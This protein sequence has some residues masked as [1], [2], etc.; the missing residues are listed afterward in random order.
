MGYRPRY[1]F[2]FD[3]PEGK[4]IEIVIADDSFDGE[5]ETRPLG[6]SPVLR[7]DTSDNVNGMSLEIPAECD[8]EDEYADLYTTDPTRFMVTLYIND[9][10]AWHGFITPELYAAPWVDPPY[11]V[12]LTAT[13]GLGEL[14]RY[15]YE[16]RGRR[17][18]EDHLI[19]LLSKTGLDLPLRYVSKL[20]HENTTDGYFFIDTAVSMDNMAGET[21]YDVLQA[22]LTSIHA[23]IRQ[24]DGRWLV[25][26]ETDVL[27]SIDGTT[28]RDNMGG[29]LDIVPF[30]SMQSNDV[31]P[32]GRLTSEIVPARN[33]VKI[34]APNRPSD[35]LLPDGDMSAGGWNTNGR[36]EQAQRRYWLGPSR[37]MSCYAVL[38]PMIE[39]STAPDL[40]LTVS[41]S[42][43]DTDEAHDVKMRVGVYGKMLDSSSM[44][45][46]Y[47]AESQDNNAMYWDNTTVK[48]VS[49]EL[50][51]AAKARVPVR[52]PQEVSID[53]PFQYLKD[54]LLDTINSIEV[55]I[56]AADAGVIVYA[57]RLVSILPFEGV[58]TTVS[59]NNGARGAAS[60]VEV[61]FADTY[62]YQMGMSWFSNS[63]WYPHS[64]L[65]FLVE[66]LA[67][68]R[69]ALSKTGVFLALDNA[70]S[71]ATPR[72][73]VK[74][75]LHLPMWEKPPVFMSTG[76]MNF[77]VSEFSYDL[78]EDE[79]DLT[80]VSAPAAT[81]QV[82]SIK[83]RKTGSETYSEA[84]ADIM[85]YPVTV[86][87]PAEGGTADL[88]VTCASGYTWEVT[89]LPEWLTASPASGQGSGV[90]TLTA[91]ANSG[92]SRDATISVGSVAVLVSQDLDDTLHLTISTNVTS[93]TIQL[94]I[95][96]VS[97]PYVSG[98]E[99]ASGAQVSVTVSKTG[100][101]SVGDTFVM[102]AANQNKYY[103]LTEI[104]WATFSTPETIT[105]AAQNVPIT[106]SDPQNHG[107][108]IDAS[109]A[110]YYGKI[111]GLGVTSGD[112]SA[113]STGISGTGDAV[114]YLTITACTDNYGRWIADSNATIYF[115]DDERGASSRS[116]IY[117]YQNGVREDMTLV[118]SVTLNKSTLSMSVGGTST[119]TATV[120]P[121]NATDKTL[122]WTSSNTSVATVT[123]AGKVT[124]VGAG[125]CTIRAT[126]NDG[127]G[128]YGSC[129]VTVSQSTV[130]VTGVSLDKS[131]TT[132]S[133]GETKQL[134][135]T[136]YPANAT[137][138]TVTWSS[139]DTSVA[140]VSSSGLV[141]AVA[142]GLATITVTTSD[143]GYTA[144][145]GVTVRETPAP[146]EPGTI[147]VNDI[148][149][150]GSV[151]SAAGVIATERIQLST[152]AASTSAL[153]V[154]QC[155]VDMSGV[156]PM[157]RL[158]FYGNGTATARTAT[159]TVSGADSSGNIV[160]TIFTLT[161]A[162]S[163]PSDVPCTAMTIDG[164][165]GLANSTNEASY[166]VAFEPE[167]TTQKAVSWSLTDSNGDDVSDKVTLT[168]DG[169]GCSLK[170]IDPTVRNLIVILRAVNAY[171]N[172]V[173]AT[174]TIMATYTL[175]SDAIQVSPGSVTVAATDVSDTTPVLTLASGIAREDLVVTTSGFIT[176]AGVSRAL[177]ILTTF[178]A[179]TSVAARSGS[180]TVSYTDPLTQE[181][182]SATVTYTQLGTSGGN[183][184]NLSAIA[185]NVQELGGTVMARFLVSFTNNT[186]SQY[187]F[188]ALGFTLSGVDENGDPTF[189]T[190]TGSLNEKTVAALS[191]EGE[192]YTV[193]WQGSVAG[194]AWY[195]LTVRNGTQLSSTLI[196][197]GNDF[198]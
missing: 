155:Y 129:A 28:V 117:L 157:V 175:P 158:L 30:G 23:T 123:Q 44:A 103:E 184:Y 165:E 45:T 86:D 57:A 150:I 94:T 167:D 169:L 51:P 99:V 126:A 194:T 130:S 37:Y 114:V 58:E 144:T 172:S 4:Q 39:G 40:K 48:Y 122:T 36:Y 12:A 168:P 164:P 160:D 174:L 163:S 82:A 183:N 63:L 24:H 80:L 106:I 10:E 93:P 185:L 149:V 83:Q 148:S 22:I 153:W 64:S 156:T 91:A 186:T 7:M 96:G 71:V 61:S 65:I 111:T 190:R 33:A 100:Y 102:S 92:G 15:T 75:I 198:I 109:M 107:W 108:T 152:L 72:L 16:A 21:C 9:H 76:G 161:Q 87:F 11:D 134:T 98:M 14:K 124:A 69:V 115:W 143:G 135:A 182:V 79:M 19:F 13:D 70:L 142:A 89:G 73:S 140:T 192:I 32:V 41:A 187:I 118:T 137:N 104:I 67:S 105:S 195:T 147:S 138:K 193:T 5:A 46:Y 141:T 177:H 47:L 133:A 8:V 189:A 173:S 176:S 120:A 55:R 29:R 196:S 52:D 50:N 27:D 20:R 18:L 74:G 151:T 178:P 136:V 162:G 90:I 146:A 145:C 110:V 35:N 1:I 85:V 38:P 59:M 131:S 34:S 132:M 181:T 127:S 56:E 113:Y 101:T 26:R 97:T 191:T 95:D 88:Q 17:T 171:N 31:W 62:G 116:N 68:S 49:R 166:T 112:A 54:N 53:I 42:I 121:S 66:T 154:Y 125:T 84:S 2:A 179:N 78:K 139:S 180:V 128:K 81:L 188:K 60:E 170:I 25:L 3:S 6:G 119:L 77:M 197:D 43:T 159:I